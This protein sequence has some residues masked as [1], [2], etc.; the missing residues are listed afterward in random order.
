M[1]QNKLIIRSSNEYQDLLFC[2]KNFCYYNKKY[3]AKKDVDDLIEKFEDSYYDL[4]HTRNDFPIEW[5]PNSDG[6]YPYVSRLT[7]MINNKEGAVLSL[8]ISTLSHETDLD[9]NY[10]Q[11]AIR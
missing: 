8:A 6:H 7:I 4:M 1:K 9:Y 5:R 11:Y 3:K 2:L 10:P